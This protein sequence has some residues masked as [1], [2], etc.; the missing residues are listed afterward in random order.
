MAIV[1][2]SWSSQAAWK[3]LLA[4]AIFP[5]AYGACS[6][7]SDGPGQ[8]GQPQEPGGPGPGAGG[9]V[10]GPNLGPEPDAP[11]IGDKDPF[12][13]PSSLPAE[14]GNGRLD[15]GERCDDG[16]KIA[17]TDPGTWDGC[18]NCDTIDP[19]FVCNEAGVD[20]VL[21]N[22]CGDGRVTPPE[23][24][25]DLNEVDGDGCSSVCSRES[26]W[27]CPVPGMPCTYAVMC[28]DGVIG[29][30]EVCDDFNA[31]DGDG[32]AANCL[33][34]E[35]GWTC[36][37]AGVKCVG[38]CGDGALAGRESCDD[39]NVVDGDGC[40]SA[41]QIESVFL[42]PTTNS[43]VGWDCA[44][45][46]AL[47]VSSVC[48]DG[49]LTGGEPCDDGDNNDLGDGCSPGCRL[50]PN[51]TAADGSC[52]SNCGDGLILAGDNEECDDGNSRS[53]D[54][55]SENCTIEA[56]FTCEIID[57]AASGASLLMPVIYRDFRGVGRGTP[58]SPVYSCGQP[59]VADSTGHPDFERWDAS[60]GA[61]T[62]ALTASEWDLLCPDPDYPPPEAA[63]RPNDIALPTPGLV[64]VALGDDGKPVLKANLGAQDLIQV[65][66]AANFNQWYRD[67]PDVN[68]PVRSTLRMEQDGAGTYVFDDI[69]FFPLDGA[70]FVETGEEEERCMLWDNPEDD[71][72]PNC[73]D[74]CTNG[75]TAD[76]GRSLINDQPEGSEELADE[77][78][79]H[80]YSFTSEVRYWF[81]YGGGEV[82]EF[83]GDDDVFVYIKRRLVVDLG[84]V[85][86]PAFGTV[87]LDNAAADVSGTA[88][89]L[90]VGRVYEAVVFQAERHT[91]QSNYKL[92]LSNF[93][94]RSS[95]CTTLCGDGVIAGDELCDD[96]EMNG[97]GYGYCNADCTPGP[98]CGDGVAQPEW[99]QC[100]NGLN[101]DT[102]YVEE[103]DCAPGC[104]F[105][106]F[107]GDGIVSSDFGERCDL[108]VAEDGV[109]SLNTGAYNGCNS[110]CTQGPRCG[111]AVI[112]EDQG[113]ECD[114]GDRRN[115]DG[116][117]GICT[118]EKVDG[119][120]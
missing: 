80:N 111:D 108:G 104:V 35:P 114:E 34:I 30:N 100:D 63:S 95:S 50:E 17:G 5:L 65:T 44:T 64:E 115:G 68:Q 45:P 98:R 48:G 101:L 89:N 4:V 69:S 76:T 27:E 8:Q 40:S 31:D 83:R 20:C 55:C 42:D 75:N 96:G 6:A 60:I 2:R 53:G 71:F 32:C 28:G 15:E 12:I 110:N 90:E 87:V 38:T 116:C 46:G 92:T 70:G 113:E 16:N 9:G 14:C 73:W 18:G 51:C 54:G 57:G 103:G 117:S 39:G 21:T 86:E 1:N 85:H 97:A 10:A 11:I 36:S 19:G 94:Q 99:E 13:P 112:Q 74:R 26:G 7:P 22:Y 78:G 62:S 77:A 88:L 79:T 33:T 23:T 82:L 24:C 93:A 52:V 3:Q 107:C 109:T 84:G 66:S 81:E 43:M 67:T 59:H 119:A 118:I 49:Q 102:Y 61:E 58:A 47:C 29:G 120:R 106:G 105:P 91:C 25:D 41:C 56:G 72:A 37:T